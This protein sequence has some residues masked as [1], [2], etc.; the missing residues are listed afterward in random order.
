M[1]SGVFLFIVT[2]GWNLFSDARRA[3]ASIAPPTPTSL[4]TPSPP[5]VATAL[6]TPSP[7]SVDAERFEYAIAVAELDGLPPDVEPGTV[8]DLW[9]TWEPP[10]V[11]QPDVQ[12]LLRDVVLERVIPPI[13]PEGPTVAVLGIP[14]TKTAVR[15]LVYGDQYGKLSVV[16][17]ADL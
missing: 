9:V 6:A 12:P 1:A 2:L 10:L 16:G 7:S 4:L 5:A 11:E 17:A 14:R 15:A 8:Y 3:P 13:V